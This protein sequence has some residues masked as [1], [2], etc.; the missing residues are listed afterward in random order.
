MSVDCTGSNRI[1]VVGLGNLL[2]RDDGVGVHAAKILDADPPAGVS[3]ADVGTA[4]WHL[5]DLLKGVD[6]L[7]AIDA[8]CAGGAPGSLYLVAAGDVPA[9]ARPVSAHSLALPEL[10]QGLPAGDRPQETLVLGVE[11][12]EV[13]V[14]MQLSPAVQAALPRVIDEVHRIVARWQAEESAVSSRRSA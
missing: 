6:F 11:P 2:M 7:L 5:P 12:D 13:E 3:V 8:M 4:I 10:L 1:L 9:R 14:G